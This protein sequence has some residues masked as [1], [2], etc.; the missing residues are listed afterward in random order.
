MIV[1]ENYTKVP[2]RYFELLPEMKGSV[3][4]IVG[5][6]IR[7]SSRHDKDYAFLSYTDLERLTG[8]KRNTVNNAIK[9]ALENKY[10]DI[11]PNYKGFNGKNCYVLG[12]R[13]GG[14]KEIDLPELDD[15]D[16]SQFPQKGQYIYL[17]EGKR[18][19]FKIGRTRRPRKRIR[20][21]SVILPFDI[22]VIHLIK[23]N[24]MVAAEQYMHERYQHKRVRG[25]WF[26]LAPE[27]I[28]EIKD[29]EVTS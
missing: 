21:L 15:L 9:E 8:L 4:K 28:A 26:E 23:T 13:L 1:T 19:Y 12:E 20:K 22:D 14:T 11:L 25:E 7:E 6:Y 17:I 27:D 16:F 29:I 2:N 3:T 10:L 5:A 18:G 24:D